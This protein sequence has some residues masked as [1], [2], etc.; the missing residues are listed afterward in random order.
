MGWGVWSI[1]KNPV[2]TVATEAI[3]IV[4]TLKGEDILKETKSLRAGD[5]T[6]LMLVVEDMIDRMA[7]FRGEKNEKKP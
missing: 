2:N 5:F 6:S 1:P 3:A 7:E 4:D